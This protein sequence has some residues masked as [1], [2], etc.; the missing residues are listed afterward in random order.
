MIIRKQFS[1]EKTVKYKNFRG[2]RSMTVPDQSMTV[3]EILTRFA[4]G[5]PVT[6]INRIPVYNG[7]EDFWG[8]KDPR[9]LDIV[10]LN[11]IIKMR[12]AQAAENKFRV[13]KD[14]AERQA[15]ANKMR[16]EKEAKE[17]AEAVAR[18]EK[19]ITR[20][21]AERKWPQPGQTEQ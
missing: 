11:E 3:K 5:I 2:Q 14:V 19:E 8:G 21:M 7:D 20:L 4:S 15:A 16:S 12:V 18:R 6:A 10:E 1:D 13:E 17:I 9:S